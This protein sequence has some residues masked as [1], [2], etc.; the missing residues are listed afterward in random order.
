MTPFEDI[1]AMSNFCRKNRIAFHCDG[2]RIFEAAIGYNR[3]L[4]EIAQ[5]FDTVYVSFY[6]GIGAITGAMLLGSN[7]FC[8]EARIWSNRFGGNLYTFLPYALSCWSNFKKAWTKSEKSNNNLLTFTE[9]YKKLQNIVQTLSNDDEISEW[10]TF[11]PCTP[12]IGMIHC[13]IPRATVSQCEM[14]KNIVFE[15]HAIK[16]FNRIRAIESKPFYPHESKGAFFEL[17]I[18]QAN[19]RI[20]DKDFYR[21][22]KAFA[23]VLA[24]I[25]ND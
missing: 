8:A 20:P 24:K 5:L 22:W 21:G 25:I 17:N 18:G 13:F 9:K 11:D 1:V 12:Q 4:A 3:D 15:K 19:G 6:K 14:A 10:L 23:Q 16:V 2:A 7:N